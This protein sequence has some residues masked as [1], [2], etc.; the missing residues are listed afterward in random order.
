M[1]CLL[2]S[3]SLKHQHSTQPIQR[4]HGKDKLNTTIGLLL[5]PEPAGMCLEA[6]K[7]QNNFEPA[8]RRGIESDIAAVKPHEIAHDRKAK[9]IAGGLTIPALTD[10]E[11]HLEGF[12]R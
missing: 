8:E 10:V 9:S 4:N 2:D 6:W 3:L 7:I 11:D 1:R 5:M 12:R